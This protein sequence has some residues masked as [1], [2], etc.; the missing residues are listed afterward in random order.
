MLRLGSGV[1]VPEDL[2]VHVGV[3]IDKTWGDD[4]ALHVNGLLSAAM[5]ASELNDFSIFDRNVGEIRRLPRS[6]NNA[7]A[8]IGGVSMGSRTRVQ[9]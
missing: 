6:V 4:E 5:N 3:V 1:R 8:T 9:V 2:R 7:P